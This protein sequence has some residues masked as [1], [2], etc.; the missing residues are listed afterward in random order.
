MIKRGYNDI[1]TS[2]LASNG[3]VQTDVR[4]VVLPVKSGSADPSGDAEGRG[5]A[6]LLA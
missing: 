3:K 4:V 1:G 6:G 2:L 5:E